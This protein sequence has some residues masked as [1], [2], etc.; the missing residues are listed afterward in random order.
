MHNVPTP[1]A[2]PGR[3]NLAWRAAERRYETTGIDHD[4]EPRDGQP[5]WCPPCTTDI[6]AAIADMPGLAR[7]LHDEIE[8][9]VSAAMAEYVSGSKNRPV[10]DHEAESFLLDEFARWI[11]DW[12]DTVRAELQLANRRP[13]ADPATATTAACAFLLPHLDWHLAGRAQHQYG[14]ITGA[15]IA[16]DFGLDMLRYHRRAK[17]LTGTQD[18]EPVRIAGVPCPVCDRKSLEYEV[19]NDTG[20]RMSATRYKYGPDGDVLT[21][22]DEATGRPVKLTESTVIGMQGAVLGYIRCRRCRPAFSMA[23]GQ[24]HAWTRLLAAGDE[25]RAL[26]TQEKLTEIFGGSIPAQYRPAS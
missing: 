20:R 9:G 22:T 23:P 19:E 1:S 12:E 2:C 6:R 25:V 18:A 21:E 15:D 3:C 8:S 14:D 5:V 11:A 26:A 13:L 17:T 16:T 4:H 7:Q 24:Y 10:H